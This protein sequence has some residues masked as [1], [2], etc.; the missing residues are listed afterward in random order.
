MPYTNPRQIERQ[1]ALAM[2]L[3]SQPQGIGRGASIAHILRNLGAYQGG[4]AASR[5][6]EENQRIRQREMAALLGGLQGD[7]APAGGMGPVRE[8]GNLPQF[9]S[10]VGD[11]ATQF[12]LQQA[13]QAA[14]P[15]KAPT[16][17]T[18]REGTESVQQQWSPT[19]QQ[20]TEVGRG[21]THRKPDQT[22]VNLSADKKYL[23]ER[24][25]SQSE[26]F[27]ELEKQADT[28]VKSNK[29]LTRFKNASPDSTEGGAQPV[30]DGVK[31]FLVSFGADFD[32]LKSLA[33]MQSGIA[34]IKASFMRELG[35]RGLTDTDMRILGQALPEISTSHEARTLVADIVMRNN[36][37][38]IGDY[39]KAVQQENE[40]YPD[41]QFIRPRWL[42]DQQRLLEAR[43]EM[44]KRGM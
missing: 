19:T 37:G 34:S 6:E 21:P 32:S 25:K 22:T 40:L 4:R 14:K 7:A 28:A 12:Q 35:A 36:E 39:L 27:G 8:A 38:V 41:Y 1:R 24:A 9:E 3:S 30:I 43:Q 31:N 11:I 5:S 26:A 17:R 13:I 23:S 44:Q 42:Q 16:T 29:A 2:Q 20:W 10:D 15:R 18:V 33:D